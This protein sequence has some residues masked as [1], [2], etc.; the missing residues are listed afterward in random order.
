MYQH[1]GIKLNEG[2]PNAPITP[3]STQVASAS[4]SNSIA[5]PS[6]STT[7]SL[8]SSRAAAAPRPPAQ[9]GPPQLPASQIAQ[10]PAPQRAH[11]STV[12][13]TQPA[14][15]IPAPQVAQPI[16]APPAAAPPVAA[17]PAAAPAPADEIAALRARIAELEHGDAHGIHIPARAPAP[18]QALVANPADLVLPAL[19][20]GHKVSALSLPIPLKVK[21]AFKQ[22]RYVPYTA[23]T[24]AARSKAFLRG[25]DSAFIFTQDGLAAKGLDRANELLIVT[26]DWIAAAKAAEDRTLHYWGEARASALVSHHLVVLDIGRA[27]GWSVE[28]HYDMQQ[29]ELAHANHE[30]NLAGL[31]IAALTIANNK[32][33]AIIPQSAPFISPPKRA[34]PSDFHSSPLA[35]CPPT[36]PPIQPQREN[37]L[38]PSLPT[39][40]ASMHSLPQ[41]ENITALIGPMD[42]SAPSVPT[43]EMSTPAASAEILL[44]VLGAARLAGDPRAV[45]TPL[46]YLQVEEI[47]RT[48]GIFNDWRHIV[49][50][51]HNG[52]NVGV[53][54]DWD[55]SAVAGQDRPVGQTVRR[56]S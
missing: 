1:L 29:R 50:G 24:Y 46:D 53:C 13:A 31:D 20:P 48:Y 32:I 56:P 45:V 34:A 28:M 14:A 4:G 27:H 30:H 54:Y 26:V 2:A 22:Y 23:L 39:P 51:I 35:T 7:P 55:S 12:H 10:H 52:F 42:P 43:A 18:Q 38:Q 16:A 40:G 5:Q 49:D 3:P 9:A 25:E 6:S 47:L 36:V 44:T 19:Q 8:P 33:P 17:P 41:T 11:P 21:E 15:P 37:R